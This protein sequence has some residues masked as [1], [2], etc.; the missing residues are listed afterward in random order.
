MP[1]PHDILGLIKDAAP[2]EIRAA[3]RRLAPAAH[4]DHGGTSEALTTLREA[5]DAA[6]ALA[7]R[8]PC[9]ICRGTGTIELRGGLRA[10]RRQCPGCAGTGKRW[11]S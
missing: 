1:D 8:A 6:L 11:R 5:R 3:F 4:P 2:A 9:A 10:L 7:W